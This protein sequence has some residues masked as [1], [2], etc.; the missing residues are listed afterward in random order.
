MKLNAIKE[1]N[2][3]FILFFFSSLCEMEGETTQN[4]KKLY[5]TVKKLFVSHL[6]LGSPVTNLECGAQI[7]K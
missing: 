7:R 2:V 1:S 6:L 4:C 3:V 5:K